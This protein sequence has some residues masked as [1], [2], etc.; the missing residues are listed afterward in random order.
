MAVS[1]GELGIS[2]QQSDG[3]G[4]TLRTNST[5]LG[6]SCLSEMASWLGSVQEFSLRT[7]TPVGAVLPVRYYWV[8][9]S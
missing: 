6:G 3:S 5:R 8:R 1:D 7:L 2:V 9:D 4:P